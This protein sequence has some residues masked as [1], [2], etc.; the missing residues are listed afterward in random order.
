[1]LPGNVTT[2]FTAFVLGSFAAN[3]P[4]PRCGRTRLGGYVTGVT[5]KQL[6]SAP[7]FGNDR[8]WDW[9]DAERNRALDDYYGIPVV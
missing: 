9:A 7:K 8:E 2:P 5:E 1:M 6:R 4:L 3:Q